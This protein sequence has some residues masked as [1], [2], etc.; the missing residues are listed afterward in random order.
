MLS[1]EQGP[2]SDPGTR[3]IRRLTRIDRVVLACGAA[4]ALHAVE[5]LVVQPMGEPTIWIR[6][7]RLV[8]VAGAGT[9]LAVAWG[10]STSRALRGLLELVVGAIGLLGG[11]VATLPRLGDLAAGQTVTGALATFGGLLLMGIGAVHLL[12]SIRTRW[13]RILA[14]PVGLLALA[15]VLAPIG[16]GVLVTNRA[17]PILGSRT[18]ADVGLRHEPVDL[19][20]P[21][22]GHLAAWYVPS[23]NGAAVLVLPGSG[24]TRDDVLD[25]AAV[26]AEHGFGVLMVDVPGHGGS[27]GEPM[28]LGWGGERYLRPALDHLVGRDEITGRIGVL[29]LSMGG[30]QA[31]TLAATDDRIAAVVSE[32]AGVRTLGDALRLP[33]PALS[34]VITAPASWLTMVTA[35]LLAD[36]SPPIPL[37]DA[38][39]R[40]AP[41]P[42][43]LISSGTAQEQEANRLYA[44]A[45]GSATYLWELPDAPHIGGLRTQPQEWERRVIA[46]LDAALLGPR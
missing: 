19:V 17:R 43:L 26:L 11:G 30:E 29:G 24:S 42:I 33:D 10:R 13:R 37:E 44:E 32:G 27:Q 39:E 1:S 2:R 15:Y 31:I 21:D 28:E 34:K 8:A 35:D 12:A 18:P 22:G 38:V 36:A 25:H 5:A 7:A 20:T 9:I 45:G 41:R 16:V 6:S 3:S 14:V 40:M 23:A 4:I 46:F